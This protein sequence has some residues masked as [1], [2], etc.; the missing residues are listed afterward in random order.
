MI[1]KPKSV[2]V[3]ITGN[4][5]KTNYVGEFL[6]KTMLSSSDQFLIA[7]KRK[8]LVGDNKDE[9]LPLVLRQKAIIIS[10]LAARIVSAP[11]WWTNSGSDLLDD[12]V[13]MDLFEKALEVEQEELAKLQGNASEAKAKLETIVDNSNKTEVKGA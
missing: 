8:Q 2:T 11:D 9:D 4:L 13:L 1:F 12:N 3:N 7:R 10:E 5:T 6:F